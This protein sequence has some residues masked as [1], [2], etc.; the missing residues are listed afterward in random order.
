[1]R[2]V[3][4]VCG[5]P[6]AGK[7]T[8]AKSLGLTV[9]DI[10]DECWGNSEAKFKA[11]LRRLATQADAQAVVIRA[12][13]SLNARANATQL[14]QATEVKVI[15]TPKAQCIERVIARNRPRPPLRV[16]I[17]AVTTWWERYRPDPVVAATTTRE[18]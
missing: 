1:M 11:A 4:L 18:W 17:A 5:P 3:I 14:V 9:Y 15:T 7:T 6:G 8:F 13:A 16:Q 12:G 10:D 2:R